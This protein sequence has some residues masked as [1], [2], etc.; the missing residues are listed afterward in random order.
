MSKIFIVQIKDAARDYYHEPDKITYIGTSQNLAYKIGCLEYLEAGKKIDNGYYFYQ[1]IQ[2]HSVLVDLLILS[3]YKNLFEKLG[4]LHPNNPDEQSFY[5]SVNVVE[6]KINKVQ[7]QSEITNVD[8]SVIDDKIQ[9]IKKDIC[10]EIVL[11]EEMIK[12]DSKNI[13]LRDKTLKFPVSLLQYVQFQEANLSGVVL[14]DADLSGANLSNVN[15]RGAFL[16]SANLRGVDL[17]YANLRNAD[18]SKA[19]LEGAD[20]RKAFW[21]GADFS[22]VVYDTNT[23]WPEDF[24]PVSAGALFEGE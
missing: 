4:R 9:S 20:L 18:L 8:S 22:N 7:I 12:L 5:F 24:D 15:L 19:H 13:S 21:E 6:L 17:Q 14:E 10:D 23:K 16:L 2:K 1:L 3:D 11:N